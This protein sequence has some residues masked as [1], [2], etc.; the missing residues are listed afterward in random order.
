MA[1]LPAPAASALAP[2]ADTAVETL[3]GLWRVEQVD[4]AESARRAV[5]GLDGRRMVRAVLEVSRE[6]MNWGYRP[7]PALPGNDI[8]SGPQLTPV[9]DA[10]LRQRVAG[11]L[12]RMGA[13]SA[14]PAVAGIDC[15]DGGRWGPGVVG[16]AYI[17]RL[18]EDRMVMTWFD[19]SVLLLQRFKSVPRRERV[20]TNQPLHASDYSR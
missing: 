18:G 9:G 7:D 11:A 10:A 1:A 2:T 17:A 8:C 16:T 20:E 4:T 12:Q 14:A 13:G 5:P 19:D 6:Q 15:D 3:A